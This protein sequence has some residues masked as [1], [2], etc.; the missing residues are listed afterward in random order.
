M[1]RTSLLLPVVLGMALAPLAGCSS[2]GGSDGGTV[3]IYTPNEESMLDALV[4]VFEA[5]TGIT[6]Q[7][8][9]AGTGE[10]YQR[11]RSEA[12]NPQGDLMFGGGDAQATQNADLWTEYVS[13]NDSDMLP[14]GKNTQGFFSPYQA[15]G[16]NLL[17]NTDLEKELGITIDGYEDLLQPELNGRIAFGDQ[18]QSSSAFAQ[19]T[20]MLLATGG[21]Y[22]SQKGWDYVSG[23]VKNLKGVTIGSSS[24]VA[25]DVANGEFAVGLTY[26]GLSLNFV[27][28]GAPVKIV[29]PEEGTVF[30]PAGIQI[31]KDGPNPEGAQAFVDFMTS[32]KGQKILAD[33]TA[34]RPL[35][36]GV[37]KAGLTPLED[38]TTLTEDSVYVSE[39]REALVARYNTMLQGS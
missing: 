7:L 37:E 3:V 22:D 18:T 16:S 11:I 4:P 10:L 5:D 38:I 2:V 1:R 6:V 23:L 20:N 15:D 13:P 36:Q 26:E 25:Q 30:L 35:R 27:N 29:Y 33:E 34:G 28:S 32:E 17:V 24:Q 9:T 8:T 39:N 14:G 12:A 19:L 31:I 21:D